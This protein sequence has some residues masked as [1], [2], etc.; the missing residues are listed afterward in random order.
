[1]SEGDLKELQDEDVDLG[2]RRRVEYEDDE[3]GTLALVIARREGGGEIEIPLVEHARTV[4][5]RNDGSLQDNTLLAVRPLAEVGR[6]RPVQRGGVTINTGIATAMLRPGYLYVFFDN[7]LWRELEIGPDGKLSDVDLERYRELAEQGET[8]DERDSEGE[9]LDD[10]LLPAML[11]GQATLHRVR[12]AYSEIAWSWPYINWLEAN[13]DRLEARTTAVGHAHAVIYDTSGQLFMQTGFPAG[14]VADQPALRERDLGI[15]LMLEAPEAF[16]TD[17]TAPADGELCT[18]LK[19]LWEQAGEADRAASLALECEAGEDLLASIRDNAGIVA[20]A[21]PDPLFTLRHALAQIHLAEHYLDGLDSLLAEKPLG[22]SAKLIRQA[23]FAE[24]SGG[25][26]PLVEFRGAIDRAK[27]DATLEQAERDAAVAVLRRQLDNLQRLVSESQLTA[28]LRDFTSHHQLGICE[29]YALCGDLYG[30]LQQLPGVLSDQ[31]HDS[32]SRRTKQLLKALLTDGELQALW[33]ADEHEATEETAGDEINDGSG[34]FRPAFLHQLAQNDSDIDDAQAASLGLETLGLITQNLAE[35]EQAQQNSVLSLANAGKVG[36]LVNAVVG[37]WS[38]AVLRVA[39]RVGDDV[40]VVHMRRVFTS[41]GTHANLVDGNLKGELQVMHRGDVDLSRYTIVGVHGDGI[42]W[43]LTNGDRTSGTF[44]TQ[45]DYLYAEQV[46]PR[47]NVSTSTSPKRMSSEVDDAI[48]QVAGHVLV[49]VLPAGHPEAAKVAQLRLAKLAGQVKVM[50]DGP[51]VSRMLVGFAIYNVGREMLNANKAEREGYIDLHRVKI[52]SAIADLAAASMKLHTALYP[53][54]ASVTGRM[55]QRPLFDMKNWPVVG[56]RLAKVGAGTL[57][58]TIGL[59]NFFAGVM[60]VGVSSWELRNSLQ[61]GDR[62]AVLGHS[63]AIAGG[64]L[65]LAAPLIS[66][67]VMIPGWGWALLGLGLAIG[68][69]SY[70]AMNQDTPFEQLLRQ[71]PLGTHPASTMTTADD[72]VYY[73]QL[74]TQ[75]SP[76]QI[77]VIRYGSLAAEERRALLESVWESTTDT[78]SSRDYVVTISTPLISRYKIGETLNLAVQELEQT[79]TGTISP[80]GTYQQLSYI[81]RTPEPFEIGKRQ[82][83]PQQSAVRFLVKRKVAEE[84]FQMGSTSVTSTARLRVALQARIEWELGEMV[85]PTPMLREYEPYVE[86]EHDAL[87]A[88]SHRTVDNP[89]ANFIRS[90]TGRSQDPRY[91]YIKEFQV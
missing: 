25:T 89:I 65:F 76:A 15:E 91:W 38:Q 47:G 88:R 4:F 36:G 12:L 86:G 43:G 51:A 3:D 32:L 35:Q 7:R 41:V 54:P 45:Q 73:P 56:R 44:Q 11:Q 62:D 16:T 72:T 39:E 8:P 55:I 14:R 46:D 84:S 31:G 85:L 48:R 57:V 33:S 6:N 78:P 74:L 61:Q 19:S 34:N 67:L 27:L 37:Q 1:M 23:M 29:G 21:L 69:T 87:P 30:V 70:A 83:L 40:E 52:G 80:L 64:A 50:I 90:F 9:W 20:V 77:E 68:G 53:E 5:E 24:P 22:H 71:G 28:V 59:V 82:L 75:L 63:V 18:K 17:F 58:R 13:P 81:T 66:G 2:V 26:N 42:E 60:T 10:I 49:Y 79:D